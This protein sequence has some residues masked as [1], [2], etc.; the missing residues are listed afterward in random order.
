MEKNKLE[1]IDRFISKIAIYFVRILF[2]M[3]VIGMLFV[4]SIYLYSDMPDFRLNNGWNYLGIFIGLLI[5]GTFAFFT[6]FLRKKCDKKY[7]N[8][9]LLLLYFMGQIGFLLL[10]PIQMFSDMAEVTKIALSNFTENMEYL[11]R[12]SNNLPI[13]LVF[14]LIFRI[15]TY[16]VWALKVLNCV[17]NCVTIYFTYR[18]YENIYG[19]KNRLVLIWGIAFIPIFLYVNM[20]YNDIIS[21]M[22]MVICLYLMTKDENQKWEKCLIPILL[23]LQFIIR[24]VGVI[25]IIA[26]MM[27][28][29]LKKK[30][31]KMVLT[32]LIVFCVFNFGYQVLESYI[33]PKTEEKMEYPVW[34]YIQMGLNEAEFGFQDGSHATNWTAKDV[35]DRMV[36]L[37]PI[38]LLKLLA[39][40]EYWLWTEGTYQAE[41][42]SFGVGTKE[43]FYYDTFLTQQLYD[44]EDSD[45]RNGLDYVMKG[46]YFC[47]ALLACIDLWGKEMHKHKKDLLLYT[48]VGIFCFYLIWEIKSRYIFC[49]Y[50]IFLVMA[51]NGMQ[52]ITNKIKL[53]KDEENGKI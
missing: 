48:I 30:S 9:I 51:T 14:N 12:C 20:V 6:D 46:Q 40:K 25:L 52:K 47:I 43:Q 32:I 23:F 49:L 2:G 41:R 8:L 33:I 18:L 50:P 31:L 4:N 39:K 24:P 1:I 38:R 13:A 36:E 15:T 34:S 27:Y 16:Q 7:T 21:T 29:G 44:V 10:V 11:Q 22:L 28:Y 19:Q 45:F 53:R 17:C 3:I 37:G 5:L 35:I 26:A 42:Y